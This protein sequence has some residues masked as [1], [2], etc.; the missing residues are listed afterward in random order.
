MESFLDALGAT[1]L[2][3]LVIVGLGAGLIAGWIAGRNRVLYAAAGVLGAVALPFVLAALGVGVIAAGG[4]L[5][6]LLVAAIGAAIVLGL[7]R[8]VRQRRR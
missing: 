3:L 4:L 7:V 1:A 6:L 2:V 5:L 8:L